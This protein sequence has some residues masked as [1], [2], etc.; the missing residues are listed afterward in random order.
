MIARVAAGLERSSLEPFFERWPMSVYVHY[1][2]PL[3][4]EVEIETGVVVSVHLVDEAIEG[5]LEVTSDADE[6][7]DDERERARRVAETSMW[8]GWTAGW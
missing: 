8:P 2:V 7:S 3:V 6:P 5:P 1:R 4:A